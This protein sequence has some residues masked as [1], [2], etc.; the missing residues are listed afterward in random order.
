MAIQVTP[1]PNPNSVKITVGRTLVP[2][3]SRTYES[4]EEAASNPIAK[5]LF[6]EEGVAI[7][8]MLGNFI[9]VTRKQGVDWNELVPRLEAA[10]RSAL[11]DA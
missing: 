7:V 9:T 2:S 1:T 6:E 11:G 5:R 8:F 4:A 3:G 10:V